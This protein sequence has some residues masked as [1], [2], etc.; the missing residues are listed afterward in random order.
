VNRPV[1]VIGAGGHAK[2]V[3]DALLLLGAELLCLTD[4]DSAKHGTSVLGVPVLGDDSLLTDYPP[5]SVDLAM[6]VG[7]ARVSPSRRRIFEQMKRMG[8][9]FRTLIH[10]GA[11]I[12]REVLLGEGCQ[13]MAGAVIQAGSALGMN[14][15]VNTRASVDHDCR[16]GDHA[17]VGPGAVLGGDVT[18]G[19]DCHIGCG[20]ALIHGVQLGCGVQVGAGAAVISHCNDETIVLGV[21]GKELVR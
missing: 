9:N 16:I 4:T 8:Y 20:A 21:P 2:V 5:G 1:V 3:V 15:L 6:G 7:S 17:H 12:G 18:L 10:P 11:L 14:V 13:V 19:A